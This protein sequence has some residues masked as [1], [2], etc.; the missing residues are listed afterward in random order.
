MVERGRPGPAV[1]RDHR[2]GAAARDRDGAGQ[3]GRHPRP[4]ACASPPTTSAP[5]TPRWPT[6][7][8]IPSTWSR[9]TAA[10]SA[11]S[12][13]TPSTSTSSRGSWPWPTGSG[14]SRHRR[15]GGDRRAGAAGASPRL[16]R[17][18][19]LALLEGRARRRDHRAVARRPRPAWT[20]LNG[21]G[22]A[23]AS[24]HIPLG[25]HWNLASSLRSD[26]RSGAAGAP[27]P[28][29]RRP[30][31]GVVAGVA[32]TGLRWCR[33][34][35]GPTSPGTWSRCTAPGPRSPCPPRPRAGRRAGSTARRTISSR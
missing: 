2:D 34:R 20:G 22:S 33:R 16:H 11:T 21:A 7:A 27:R 8:A 6:S 5:A 25:V 31:W 26:A 15:G 14:M 9:S 13:P 32:T 23:P 4:R 12:P 17:C 35:R 24:V 1:R 28:A 3:P 30:R 18:P 19:G 10:S 29:A